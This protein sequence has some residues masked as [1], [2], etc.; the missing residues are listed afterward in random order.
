VGLAGRR[1]FPDLNSSRI[2]RTPKT[3]AFRV[4]E[5]GNRESV[6]GVVGCWRRSAH[7]AQASG[8]SPP[9]ASPIGSV[10]AAGSGEPRQMGL[11][12]PAL[13]RRQLAKARPALSAC[14][15]HLQLQNANTGHARNEK[16]KWTVRNKEARPQ[17]SQA[18][19]L[20]MIANRPSV[21]KIVQPWPQ[22]CDF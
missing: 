5:I 8:C 7:P 9:E 10:K 21:G 15:V 14:F 22:G 16:L 13:F 6:L 1:A 2:S 12:K 17:T 20:L 3:F 4:F 19:I 11:H 18:E